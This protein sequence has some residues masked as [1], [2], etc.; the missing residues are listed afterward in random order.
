[1]YL[2]GFFVAFV[3]CFWWFWK[4]NAAPAVVPKT[5][6]RRQSEGR[7]LLP[8]VS[9]GSAELDLSLVPSLTYSDFL[10]D[11]LVGAHVPGRVSDVYRYD[12]EDRIEPSPELALVPWPAFSTSD[13]FVFER[14][15]AIENAVLSIDENRVKGEERDRRAIEPSLALVPWPL[16]SS[17]DRSLNS[18]FV[19]EKTDV[20]N[21]TFVVERT[22]KDK[23]KGDERKMLSRKPRP[24]NGARSKIPTPAGRRPERPVAKR[25]ESKSRK[26]PPRQQPRKKTYIES[27]E[28]VNAKSALLA[29]LDAEGSGKDVAEEISD[30]SYLE[31]YADL[32][33]RV[34]ASRTD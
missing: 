30:G 32:L 31:Y 33:A 7:R 3:S 5:N 11:L 8:P 19:I 10:A 4:R 14:T 18:T 25:V 21:A 27:F 6:R 34:R 28:D 23:K 9:N 20:M 29:R 15:L 1:M 13:C 22:A 2:F 16:P 17:A 24:V 26:C 12:V